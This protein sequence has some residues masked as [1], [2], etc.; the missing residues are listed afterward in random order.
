MTEV[1][2][3]PNRRAFLPGIIFF[4]G[5][6]LSNIYGAWQLWQL[7][8]DWAPYFGVFGIMFGIATVGGLIWMTRRPLLVYGTG[9][10]RVYIRADKPIGVPIEVVEGFLL[11]KQEAKLGR[12]QV[13][14]A[15][16]VI[17][18]AERATEYAKFE[19]HPDVGRWCGGYINIFGTWCEP[20]SVDLVNKLNARL[21]EVTKQHAQTRGAS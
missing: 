8:V 11:G 7:Q 18:L 13:E 4:V 1:W 17:R 5:L 16:L 12:R 2:L 21:A 19:M 10:L 6:S 15:T 14:I 20:L 9:K 3:R